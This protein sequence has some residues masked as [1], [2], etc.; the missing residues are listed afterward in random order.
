MALILSIETS[1]TVCSVAI[2]R[3]G[4]LLANKETDESNAHSSKLMLFIEACLKESESSVQD[5]NAIAVSAG[6]GSYTGLR[7]GVSTA[8]GLAYAQNIPIVAVSAMESLA[9]KVLKIEADEGY[10]IPVLDARRMEVYAQVFDFDLQEKKEIESV[11]L[12][13]GSFANLLNEGLV[14][15]IGDGASKTKEVIQSKNAVFVEGSISSIEMGEVAWK[16]FQK[17]EFEDIAYFVPNYLKE[18]KVLK[19]KKNLLLK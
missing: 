17:S 18:F 12:D 15:F 11:I 1:T 6:P 13:Q 5:L 4:A 16:K 3:D 14:Y 8:K 7:I 2:H 10:I 19:S 9:K